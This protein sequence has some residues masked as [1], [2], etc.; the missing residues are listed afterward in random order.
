[1]MV[2][3][4]ECIDSFVL[5]KLAD[6]RSFKTVD[7]Y[8]SDLIQF[9][10]YIKSKN[11]SFESADYSILRKYLNWLDVKGTAASTRARKV[12]TLKSFYKYL[13]QIKAIPENISEDLTSPKIPHK[14]PKIIPLK[15][16][17]DI[18][19]NSL[20]VINSGDYSTMFFRDF[21]IIAVFVF[22]GV[23]REELTNIKLS[24]VDIENRKI[25]IHGKG[26]KERIV[27]INDN[28]LP[29][30]SEYILVHRGNLYNAKYS[31]YLFVSK[32]RKKLTVKA[33]N[34]IVNKN[35]EKIGVKEKGI[36]AH[37][38]RKCF[39]TSLFNSTHDI[40]T[41]SKLLGHTSPTVTMRYIVVDEDTKRNVI[42]SLNYWKER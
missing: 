19:S 9:S 34:D 10:E 31:E 18:I 37:V 32:K 6:G 33:V 21:T 28:L 20:D 2:N 30:L 25:L 1:M 13:Y 5:S 14:E 8:K 11:A 40:T 41:I 27:Y 22:S 7:A 23:R 24:D 4:K 29:I 3:Q 35:L 15:S 16:V 36:S 17:K 26:N 42:N 12:S 38:L 39:A